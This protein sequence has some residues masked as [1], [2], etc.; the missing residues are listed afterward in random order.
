MRISKNNRK[1]KKTKSHKLRKTKK[2]I[3]GVQAGINLLKDESLVKD[4]LL[5]LKNKVDEGVQDNHHWTQ[6]K[7]SIGSHYTTQFANLK[8]LIP[9]RKIFGELN[10]NQQVTVSNNRDIYKNIT[11]DILEV[12]DEP[13]FYVFI[14]KYYPSSAYKQSPGSEQPKKEQTDRE[15]RERQQRNREREQREREQRERQQRNREREQREREQKEREQREREQR[16]REREQR[17]REREQRNKEREQRERE[18]REREEREQREREQREQR[19]RE[20]REREQSSRDSSKNI[21]NPEESVNQI[22]VLLRKN[23]HKDSDIQQIR[24][25]LKDFNL[26]LKNSKTNNVFDKQTL[27]YWINTFNSLNHRFKDLNDKQGEKAQSEK[28]QGAK[29]QSEKDPG[30]KP[31]SEK[32][33]SEKSKTEK[34]NT[35]KKRKSNFDRINNNLNEIELLVNNNILGKNNNEIKIKLQQLHPKIN[36]LDDP[37][38]IDST[39]LAILKNRYDLLWSPFE[40]D[41]HNEVLNQI[42][43]ELNRMERNTPNISQDELSILYNKLANIKDVNGFQTHTI[44]EYRN[45]YDLIQQRIWSNVTNNTTHSN[46]AQSQHQ[47]GDKVWSRTMKK[48][49]IVVEPDVNT[50]P[51]TYRILILPNEIYGWGTAEDLKPISTLSVGDKL[52]SNKLG[53][54]IISLMPPDETS[55]KTEGFKCLYQMNGQK[56]VEYIY[57]NDLVN[58]EFELIES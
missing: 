22:E 10:K 19:E 17:N 35:E 49:A 36:V 58:R 43:E 34:E 39:Q 30:K 2:H 40:L 5:A 29:T 54:L 13:S 6:I 7:G 45:R 8:S 42:N 47:I 52:K 31:K 27:T 18:Q 55:I 56:I 16:N 46:A 53:G 44:Q 21:W 3:G 4:P 51:N 41:K 12:T 26:K 1:Y 48:W 15:Q 37:N 25:Y 14:K 11:D 20:E 38:D 33:Q 28:T 32:K 23:K 24:Q 9:R 57:W 50:M